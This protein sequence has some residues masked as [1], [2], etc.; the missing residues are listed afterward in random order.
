MSPRRLTGRS[1]GPATGWTGL[2]RRVAKSGLA[3]ALSWTG[4]DRV[5]GVLNG[6]RREPLVLGYHGVVEDARA[7]AGTAIPAILTGRRTLERHHED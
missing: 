5:I 6:S 2:P 4:T 3:C 7:H 1:P